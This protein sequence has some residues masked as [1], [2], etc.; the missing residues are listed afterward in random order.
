MRLLAPVLQD[1][2]LLAKRYI[3]AAFACHSVDAGPMNY[4]AG[5]TPAGRMLAGAE[6]V[7]MCCAGDV[8]ASPSKAYLGGA[9]GRGMAAFL[10]K[11]ATPQINKC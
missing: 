5:Y 10:D 11:L 4:A 1:M 9:V 8:L 6:Q 3:L 7:R 2:R